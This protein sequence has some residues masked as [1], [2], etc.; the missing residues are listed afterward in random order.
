MHFPQLSP[1]INQTT[2]IQTNPQQV[3][4]LTGDSSAAAQA[5][6]R[7]LGIDPHRV[8]AGTLPGHKAKRVKALQVRCAVC[9]V[10]C[11]ALW[12][13]MHVPTDCP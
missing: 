7:S 12:T 13:C 2:V 5:V 6:A 8:H 10:L 4:M 9:E 11:I 1:S 3:W